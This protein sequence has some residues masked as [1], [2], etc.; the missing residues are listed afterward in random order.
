MSKPPPI[1]FAYHV[2]VG[3]IRATLVLV[4]R[5]RWSGAE[6]LP[7][8]G[9]IAASNH[10]SNM[11]AL[12]FGHFLYNHGRPPKYLAK[13][14][15][16]K[17]PVLGW[18]AHHSGQIPVH[19][20]T[21]QAADALHAAEAALRAGECVGLFPEGTLTKDPNLWPMVAKTGIAR[22]ALATRVPVIPIAQWGTQKILPRST[23][24]LHPFPPQDVWVQAGPPVDLSDLYGVPP[25]A[26]VLREATARVMARITAMLADI[27][28]ETPPAEPYDR[29]LEEGRGPA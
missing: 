24:R 6:N 15:V 2:A 26:E 4:T 10:M 16:F 3:I 1:P 7:D 23:N 25:D 5:K 22:L 17:V 11:D 18:F 19:R 28:H 14:S 29:G 13:A 8:G 12:T 9:F 20:G 21:S 27:R